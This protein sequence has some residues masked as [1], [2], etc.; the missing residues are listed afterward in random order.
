MHKYKNIKQKAKTCKINT[1]KEVG[2][3]ER[4]TQADFQLGDR[5]VLLGG[6]RT[7]M[8]NAEAGGDFDPHS[9]KR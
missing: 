4:E 5:R 7:G 9:W 3:F 6:G 2:E 8:E 1:S